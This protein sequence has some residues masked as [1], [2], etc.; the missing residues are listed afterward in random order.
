LQQLQEGKA[1]VDAEVD[2]DACPPFLHVNGALAA[3]GSVKAFIWRTPPRRRLNEIKKNN[4]KQPLTDSSM[5]AQARTLSNAR[6]K[7]SSQPLLARHETTLE[8]WLPPAGCPSWQRAASTSILVRGRKREK[9]KEKK[10]KE[11]GMGALSADA[12]RTTYEEL[13]SPF[14]IVL[15][16]PFLLLFVSR[17]F[18]SHHY[19]NVRED[20][21]VK[22]KREI[23]FNTASSLLPMNARM[24]NK[25]KHATMYGVQ[26]LRTEYSRK[27]QDNTW[28]Y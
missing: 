7:P 12:V 18:V 26:V 2:A 25:N 8:I 3:G 1:N 13:H 16:L 9:E 24:V 20:S 10:R 28:R 6:P 17:S 5:Q 15:S 14:C 22:R 27:I 19:H 4:K 11:A 21:R 23:T